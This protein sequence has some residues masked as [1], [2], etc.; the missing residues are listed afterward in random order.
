MDKPAH[1]RLNFDLFKTSGKWAYGQ[2]LAIP[3][4]TEPWNTAELVAAIRVM[5]SEVVDTVF[6]SGYTLVVTQ[7][8]YDVS[9]QF[10]QRLIQLPH[11]GT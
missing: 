11:Q 1:T 7:P 2:S 6:D 10:L 3:A 8:D 4:L 9:E 5:Q